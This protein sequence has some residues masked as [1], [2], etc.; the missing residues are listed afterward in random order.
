MNNRPPYVK[1]AFSASELRRIYKR[2]Q[3]ITRIL[4]VLSTLCNL[5]AIFC[6]A[7][8]EFAP[9]LPLLMVALAAGGSAARIERQE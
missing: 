3:I 7:A 4:W 1:Q 9:V 2:R 5:A 6:L 8:K